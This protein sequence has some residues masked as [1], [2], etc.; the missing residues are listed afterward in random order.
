M[1]KEIMEEYAKIEDRISKEDF[2]AKMEA[3]KKDYEDVS[4]MNDLDIARMIVGT[5]IDEKNEPISDKEEY[6]MDKISK[7]ESGAQNF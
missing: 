1:N 5:F 2:L 3:M 7:L 4:F 6:A